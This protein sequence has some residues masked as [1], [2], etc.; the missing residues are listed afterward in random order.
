MNIWFPIDQ[1]TAGKT[2]NVFK[3]T[4]SSN[5]AALGTALINQIHNCKSSVCKAYGSFPGVHSSSIKS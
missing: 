5:G 3:C 1:A 4:V 2:N